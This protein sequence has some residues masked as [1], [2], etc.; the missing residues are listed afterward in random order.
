MK[1]T[2]L[3]EY[4]GKP[5]SLAEDICYLLGRETRMLILGQQ[6]HNATSP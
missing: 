6:T 1:A 4:V 5:L 3:I 2:Y